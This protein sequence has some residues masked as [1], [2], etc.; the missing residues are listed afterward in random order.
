MKCKY[1]GAEVPDNEDFC[2]E[3]G[4]IVDREEDEKEERVHRVRERRGA[5]VGILITGL[6]VALIVISCVA[7]IILNS[8]GI[9]RIPE[10]SCAPNGPDD[11]S[12]E[13]KAPEIVPDP[14]NPGRYLV[15]VYA[16]AGTKVIF[17]TTDGTRNEVEVPRSGLVKFSV[18][19]RGL[20]PFEPI[21]SDTCE[22]VPIIFTVNEDGSESRVEGFTPIKLSVPELNVA[23]DNDD[24]IVSTD[25]TAVI[26][27]SVDPVDA[28]ITVQGV[29]V[30]V[31]SDGTFSYTL[32]FS[33]AG[34]HIVNI[35]ARHPGYRIVRRSFTVSVEVPVAGLL[36]FPWEYGDDTFT[37]RVKND[38]D[39]PLEVRGHVPAG[40][41]VT[42][43][44]ASD[45]A[46]LTE[47]TVAEDGTFSF[48]VKM[49]RAG[50]Y[51]LH[52]TCYSPTGEVAE[53]VLHVQRAP[54]W[55]SYVEGSW[56]M[57]YD[58]LR[59]ASKQGYKLS[60][61][62]TEVIEDGDSMVVVLDIGN[63]NSV[64]LIYH[65]HYPNAGSLALGS[66]HTGIYGH[67]LGRNADGVPE[68]YVWFIID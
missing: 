5:N 10:I 27:G 41:K 68:V 55:R 33:E 32:S 31:G 48:V 2:P 53:R 20:I 1:C 40:S 34:S 14:E 26:S 7:V 30:T 62:V 49:L 12:G 15:T 9:I 60:G 46:E 43:S 63:G 4:G 19:D 44:C 65:H 24:P 58:A 6:I 42:V 36:E 51:E 23:F 17:Q 59:V 3:C 56:A 13:V 47:P 22:V 8:K 38:A 29:T 45:M 28:E 21:E 50:D 35:E 25:G 64:I 57:S 66:V 54:E 52:I 16:K 11:P 61:T 39:D 18:P 37:T 67:P